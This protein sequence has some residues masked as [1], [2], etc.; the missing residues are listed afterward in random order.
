MP[1]SASRRAAGIVFMVS[2]ITSTCAA[3]DAPV[4]TLKPGTL[5]V[6][7]YAGFAPFAYRENGVW[8]GWD[9]DYLAAFANAN[10]LVLEVI[11][12]PRFEDIWLRPGEGKCDIAGSGISDTADRRAAVNLGGCWSKSYYDV[13]R[14][15]LMRSQDRTRL[16]KIE[17][18]R[19]TTTIV[20]YGS[21]AHRD[22][23]YRMQL[24]QMHACTTPDREDPCANLDEVSRTI[25]PSCVVVVHPRD[26]NEINA[27]TDI[28]NSHGA[29]APFAYGGG[30][31]SVQVLVSQI[32]G[33]SLVWPHCNMT[34]Y[35]GQIRPYAEPF[36]FV[37][38]SKSP[39]LIQALNKFIE[40]KSTPYAGSATPDLGCEAP[41]WTLDPPSNPACHQ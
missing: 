9:V 39:G 36:S 3:G 15:F 41:P 2:C 12:E 4:A 37:V 34:T 33:L 14:S 16:T 24:A 19:G 32:P 13:L 10:D 1:R 8:K 23:C 5:Q 22:L 31:G 40:S 27:A 20:T 25:D 30:Y 26:N 38:S 28:A 17:D 7:L 18:L 6:C 29:D 11:E 21:T 35:G